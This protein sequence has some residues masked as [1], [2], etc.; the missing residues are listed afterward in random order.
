[1]HKFCGD[2]DGGARISR[3]YE[4]LADQISTLRTRLVALAGDTVEQ[5][6]ADER[7]KWLN[8][9]LAVLTERV[10]QEGKKAAGK[11]GGI[12]QERPMA[13]LAIAFGLG[14]VA[15][16]MLR[17]RP[18]RPELEKSEQEQ[19]ELGQSE[20]GQTAGQSGAE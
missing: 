8:Q 16:R 3:E 9:E 10:S 1:M 4:H 19:S 12:V 15:A 13:S 17:R 7:I 2:R 14:F 6:S 11:A 18:R 5:L 20:P